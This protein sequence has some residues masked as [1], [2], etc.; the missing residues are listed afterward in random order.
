MEQ[1]LVSGLMMYKN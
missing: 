1:N